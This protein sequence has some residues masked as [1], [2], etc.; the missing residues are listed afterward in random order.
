MKEEIKKFFNNDKTK[1]TVKIILPILL[2]IIPL[3]LCIS[4]R[5]T[6]QFLPITDSWAK[7]TIE[8]NLRSQIYAQLS[9][10]YPGLGPIELENLIESEYQ[11]IYS[12]QQ[13]QLE[14]AII[15]L[16]QSF[17]DRLR[18]EYNTTYLYELDPYYYYRNAKNILD[19]GYE[20]DVKTKDGYVDTYIFAGLPLEYRD[21]NPN[22]VW[23]I[24]PWYEAITYKVLNKIG[25][26]VDLMTIAFYASTVFSSIAVIFAFLLGKDLTKSNWGGFFAALVVS[27]HPFLLTR[28]MGGFS[29]TDAFTV[30]F[31]LLA[32]FFYFRAFKSDK[33]LGKVIYTGLFGFT[34]FLFPKAWGGWWYS[35]ILLMGTAFIYVLYEM[36]VPLIK[37]F[38][39]R[40]AFESKSFFKTIKL[41]LITFLL[42]LV[43]SGIFISI[44]LKS[45][46]A[47]LNTPMLALS[48]R[49]MLKSVG[50]T[51]IWPNVFTTVAELNP[52]SFSDLVANNAGTLGMLMIG[53]GIFFSLAKDGKTKERTLVPFFVMAFWSLATIY[54]IYSGVRFVLL[55]VPIVAL[56]FAY[57]GSIGVEK[58]AMFLSKLIEIP[59]VATKVTLITLL[60]LFFILPSG[61]FYQQAKRISV[62]HV[63]SFDDSWNNALTKIDNEASEDAIIN[64]WW[65]FGHWFKAIGNRPTTLDGGVQN[66][67]QAHWLGRLM[68]TNDENLSIAILRMLDCGANKAF[69]F[70]AEETNDSYKA[71]QIL[72]NALEMNDEDAR[73]YLLDTV[74]EDTTKLVMEHAFCEPPENYFVT[75]EDMVGKSGVWA[76]FG[77]WD[78][79]RAKMYAEVK[80][81][82]SLGDAEKYLIDNFNLSQAQASKYVSEIRVQTGDEWI[83]PWPSYFG[84]MID[85]TKQNETALS[86]IKRMDGNTGIAISVD[87]ENMEAYALAS[88]QE[89]LKVKKFVYNKANNVYVKEDPSSVFDYGIILKKDGESYSFV[90]CHTMLADSIFTRLFFLDGAG[91]NYFDLFH[92][93]TDTFGNDFYIWKV[94]WKPEKIRD[95]F[96]VVDSLENGDEDEKDLSELLDEDIKNDSTKEVETNSIEID[97]VLVSNNTNESLLEANL[98]EFEDNS[99]ESTA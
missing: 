16:S 46:T 23:N 68:L 5:V 95:N 44:T 26:N 10:Q 66:H 45:V 19:H 3:M 82:K 96:R 84:G 33:L 30:L 7:S 92:S 67:P 62:G 89:R 63:P 6:S 77:S 98:S 83:S 42:L 28:T 69:D 73:S 59:Q 9:S 52:G 24:L 51:T 8:N 58:I 21:A 75:S 55:W 31:A 43:F 53:A 11:R 90:I 40:S 14:Q 93:D 64:S 12:E 20:A 60:I 49:E 91:T 81:R 94:N 70:L 38:R 99:S 65:D 54:T 48:G 25:F 35:Y 74:G 85:C 87:L 36:A 32:M 79:T 17:K 50:I 80:A 1:K 97:E 13:P 57:I 71:I 2:F 29:D 47:F 72:N 34:Y 39:K 4:F 37:M 86:C 88:N 41:P 61:G 56:A 18:T 22:K 78:F 76:H 27:I 15:Q